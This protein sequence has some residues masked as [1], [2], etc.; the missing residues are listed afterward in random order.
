MFTQFWHHH[1]YI[2]VVIYHSI[3]VVF[4]AYYADLSYSGILSIF[5][6]S[7]LFGL[8]WYPSDN[9]GTA[10][11]CDY[12]HIHTVLCLLIVLKEA[13]IAIRIGNV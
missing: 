13:V 5:L 10:I 9:N 3:C 12:S 11:L 4:I 1:N 8:Y 7:W 6:C 2:G